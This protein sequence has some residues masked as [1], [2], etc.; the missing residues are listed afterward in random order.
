MD[1]L[2]DSDSI[3][4]VY[5]DN[6][7]IDLQDELYLFD[8]SIQQVLI[9]NQFTFKKTIKECCICY[10]QKEE[11]KII[12]LKKC[13]HEFCLKCIKRVLGRKYKK[14]PCPSCRILF[15]KNDIILPIDKKG[16][17][18]KCGS[19]YHKKTNHQLCPLNKKNY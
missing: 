12:Y 8:R 4:L 2:F 19:L 16:N 7:I 15:S 9:D 13:Q 14:K 5:D 10:E 17:K 18:C 6:E 3:K 11:D 1:L